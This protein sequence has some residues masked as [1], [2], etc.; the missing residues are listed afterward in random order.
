MCHILG[1]ITRSF[2]TTTLL[3]KSV[4]SYSVVHITGCQLLLHIK[5]VHLKHFSQFYCDLLD[6]LIH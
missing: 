5:T 1:A 4:T 6:R 3:I 2:D